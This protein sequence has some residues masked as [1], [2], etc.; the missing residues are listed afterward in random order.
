MYDYVA[1]LPGLD[2]HWPTILPCI[3]GAIVF[4]FIYFTSA[5]RQSL[6]E[7]VYVET[8]IGASVFFWHDGSYVLN[9]DL[10]FNHYNHWWFKA[11]WFALIGTAGFEAYLIYL[12]FKFGH[13]ELWPS[14]TREAFGALVVVGTLAV[15]TFWF[16]IKGAMQDDQYF[17]TF[18]ITAI[19][20]AP[21]HTAIMCMRKNRAGQSIVRQVCMAANLVLLTAAFAQVAPDYFLTPTYL[22]WALAFTAWP[23]ANIWLIRQLPPRPAMAAA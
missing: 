17:I 3:A 19:W 10:W 16:L 20:S 8:F 9:Y 1:V 11:W 15:G 5:V 2:R 12:F 18:A 21:F 13:K 23:L 14:L 22:A 4:S 7:K 6:T